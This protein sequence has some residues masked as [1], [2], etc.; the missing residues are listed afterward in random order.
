MP[1]EE[2]HQIIDTILDFLHSSEQEKIIQYVKNTL[3]HFASLPLEPLLLCMSCVRIFEAI[4]LSCDAKNLHFQIHD[5]QQKILHAGNF[6]ILKSML[7]E[8]L[9]LLQN[10]SEEEFIKYKKEVQLVIRYLNMNY[11]K[12]I[13]LDEIA[14]YANLNKSY[15][16]RLF[17]KEYGDSIFNYL[18]SVRMEKAAEMLKNNP[19]I[20]VQEVALAVGIEEPFY[21]TR[22][23]KEY[24]GVSPRDYAGRL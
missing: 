12:H 21:F 18:N 20:Y 22:R 23:F 3:E 8:G 5:Y 10:G 9:T 19:N 6:E 13:S 24:F 14:N 1:E 15:L 16:C 17:K 11:Q 4:A 7:C 2:I